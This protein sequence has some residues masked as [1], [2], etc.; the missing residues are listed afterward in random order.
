MITM[1]HSYKQ[2]HQRHLYSSSNHRLDSWKKLIE[3]TSLRNKIPTS[4]SSNHVTPPRKDCLYYQQ[5]EISTSDDDTII[6]N[7]ESKNDM[8]MKKKSTG[9][10]RN[11][12]Q[13]RV[14]AK[15]SSLWTKVKYVLKVSS[16]RNSLNLNS[17]VDQL[18]R[19]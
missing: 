1:K 3:I 2:Q 17:T 7:D 8:C 9:S 14:D 10:T 16:T 11:M 13:E 18:Y 15:S 12:E 4:T 19:K 6:S 5:K